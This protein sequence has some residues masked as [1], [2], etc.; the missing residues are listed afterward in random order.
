LSHWNDSAG[1]VTRS[2]NEWH[3]VDRDQRAFLRKGLEFSKEVY[4]RI[5]KELAEQP[6]D[7]DG[8]KGANIGVAPQAAAR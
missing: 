3:L 1:R 8:L 2:F 4:D 6:G 7:P 5:W